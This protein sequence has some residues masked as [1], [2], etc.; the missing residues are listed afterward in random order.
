VEEGGLKEDSM[1]IIPSRW[2]SAVVALMCASLSPAAARDADLRILF[3]ES[4][5]EPPAGQVCVVT[6]QGGALLLK[7][8]V[9]GVDRIYEGG[10]VLVD[11]T[12]LIRHVGCSAGRPASLDAIASGATRVEC[13]MGIISPGLINSH[14]HLLFDHNAPLPDAGDRFV[15]RNEWRRNSSV[16]QDGSAAKVL[17]SELRQAMIGTT[18]ILGSGGTPGGLRNLDVAAYPLLDDLLWNIHA[19]PPAVIT[20]ET[21]P[22]EGP[23]DYT[24][25]EGDCA[26][27]PLYPDL[28]PHESLSDEYVPHV[29]EGINSAAHNEFACLSS[30]ARNGVDV[31][32][33][34]FSMIHGMA[35][36]AL[37]GD[38]LAHEGASVIWSPRSNMSLYGNTA[39]VSMLKSQGVLLSLGTDWTPSGSANLAREL[40]CADTLNRSY[41]NNAFTDRELWMMTTRNPAVALGIDDKLGALSAGLFGD[42]AI[43]DGRGKDNPYRA[44]IEASAQS[45]VLV[46]RRSSLPFSQIGGPLYA[47][48]IGLYGDASVMS[49]LP[50]TLHDVTA[51]TFGV[52][53]PLCEILDVCGKAKTICP[54]RETW[55]LGAAGLGQPLPLGLL[56]AANAGSYNLF[57]CGQPDV[58]PTC[59]PFRAGEYGGPL[60]T[61]GP[62][63]DRDGDGVG[64]A[65]D[66][67][68]KV[69]NPIRPMDAGIQ[70]DSDGDG[71]G[72]AC[73]RCPLDPNDDCA[74][75]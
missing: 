16:P 32:D 51:P 5:P 17:W 11:S 18:S 30:T 60:V 28:A 75:P 20:T 55:W 48:S 64:D 19:G 49:A 34:G 58:E 21:F 23:A 72:D 54:L 57:F 40:V 65:A 62:K 56:Q 15:H 8:Q 6:R 67:C 4:L 42:I 47:G 36:T 69:F 9:L 50:P 39:P 38:T 22:L 10:E 29:A 31:V 24:Q 70:P 14:D 33:A 73:D 61:S 66:N 12:G 46:L 35:L 3:C 25:N 37:D 43:Y 7:G 45:T 41:L 2:A 53:A 59:T 74:R 26:A 63:R 52:T 71:R 44:I 27:F 68:A 1:R 13:A